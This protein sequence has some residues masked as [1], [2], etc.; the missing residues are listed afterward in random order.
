MQDDGPGVP[1]GQL[2]LLGQR[3]RRLGSHEVEG[4]GL[5]LSIVRRIVAL[6]GGQIGFSN[7][8]IGARSARHAAPARP[9]RDCKPEYHLAFGIIP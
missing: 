2:A 6:H 9:H 4:V 8:G 3:F 1:E 7:V 5:G